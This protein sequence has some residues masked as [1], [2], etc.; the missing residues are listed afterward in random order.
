MKVPSRG[1]KFDNFVNLGQNFNGF[2]FVR[3]EEHVINPIYQSQGDVDA[4]ANVRS[5]CRVLIGQWTVREHKWLV[6]TAA[7][8]ELSGFK[9]TSFIWP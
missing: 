6:V 3:L 5:Q 1:L 8:V 2:W 4:S 9:L 7:S